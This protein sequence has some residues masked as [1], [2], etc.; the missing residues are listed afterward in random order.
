MMGCYAWEVDDTPSS[1]SFFR[2][3]DGVGLL[4]GLFDRILGPSYDVVAFHAGLGY[5]LVFV[6]KGSCTMMH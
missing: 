1:S 5:A 4:Q 6:L 3:L 2:V